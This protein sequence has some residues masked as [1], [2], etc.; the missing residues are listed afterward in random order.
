MKIHPM[1]KLLALLF[2]VAPIVIFSTEY[3][4]HDNDIDNK[5]FVFDTTIIKDGK[6]LVK[7]EKTSSF[8]S[9]TYKKK[10]YYV[11]TNHGRLIISL[12]IIKLDNYGVIETESNYGYLL[13]KKIE[14]NY[15]GK[16]CLITVEKY[17]FQS[18]YHLDSILECNK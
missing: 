10:Y 12:P 16:E 9:M 15:I 4:N 5:K 11:F 6:A 14:E 13:S 2:I 17:V 7:I 8:F 1:F 3:K 18:D